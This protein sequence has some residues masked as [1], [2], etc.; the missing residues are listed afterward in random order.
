MAERWWIMLTDKQILEPTRDFLMTYPYTTP[1]GEIDIDYGQVEQTGSD[2]S[3]EGN[4]LRLIGRIKI[5]ERKSVTGV[6]TETWRINFALVMRRDTN[7]NN[8]RMEISEFILQFI[9]W[10]NS[11]NRKRGKTGANP[12]LPQ[13]SD[14]ERE[15]ISADGGGQTAMLPSGRDEFQVALHLDFQTQYRA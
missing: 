6:V 8:L 12:K 15:T 9:E 11:E 3:G 14:T 10:V 7:D 13:F 5:R 2:A 4:A 1:V